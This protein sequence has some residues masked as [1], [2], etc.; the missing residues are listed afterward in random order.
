MRPAINLRRSLLIAR[1]DYLGYIKTW[2]FWI[3]FCLPVIGGIVG[4]G[5]SKLNLDFD[6]VRY[7]TILD[8]TGQYKETIIARYNAKAE[9]IEHGTIHTLASVMLSDE[10]QTELHQIYET[11]GIDAAKTRLDE[12]YPGASRQLK[13]T[14]PKTI[15]VDPPANTLEGLK[16]YLSGKKLMKDDGQDVELNGVLL[17]RDTNPI[18]TEYW[19]AQINAQD[20]KSLAN[21]YFKTRA[22]VNYLESGGL[23]KTGFDDAKSL[24]PKASSFDPTKIVRDESASQAV[25]KADRIPYIVAAVMALLLWLSVFSGA[26]ML[27]T[28]MLEEKLNKLLE[29]M[30]ATTRFSEIIFG[31]LIGVAALTLTAMLPYILLGIVAV[32]AVIIMAPPEISVALK[33]AFTPKLLIFF[34]IFLVLGYV[35]YGALFI[36]MG[37]MANS[38]QDAQTITTPIV[39]VLTLCVM[40]VPIGIE[41]PDSPILAFAAWFPLSA[42]FAAIMRL[43]SDPPL[44][45]LCLSAGFLAVLSI[46]VVWLA[47]RMFRYG[48]LSGASF[49]G[50]TDWIKRKVFRRKA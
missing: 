3:S 34:P 35:F 9:M 42:P 27:L 48:V 23:S 39:L 22:E 37:A 31:K 17:I 19:S 15:F 20:V 12:F 32:I 33:A 18:E 50:V 47:G 43:P 16:P 26:Y 6:P 7:E 28:S 5:A 11:Q 38:M 21:D 14:E 44:W 45:E 29:M 4:V 30:L 36:A 25:T 46:G 13:A 2:G 8:E 49:K 41:S 1:R 24:A 40:V 10:N